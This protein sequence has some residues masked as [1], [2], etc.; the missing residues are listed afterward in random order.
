MGRYGVRVI[1]RGWNQLATREFSSDPVGSRWAA[2][3]DGESLW[4]GSHVAGVHQLS[5]SLETIREYPF[6]PDPFGNSRTI[7]GLV[8]L[9][10]GRIAWMEA[11]GTRLRPFPLAFVVADPRTG[12]W[13]IPGA[14]SSTSSTATAHCSSTTTSDEA[15]SSSA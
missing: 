11:R 12:S 15:E 3:W 9:A 4:F 2:A 1:D 6:E 8:V 10:D 13:T 14:I 5:P 7:S